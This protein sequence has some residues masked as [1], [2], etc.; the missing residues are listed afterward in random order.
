MRRMLPTIAGLCFVLGLALPVEADPITVTSGVL[1]IDSFG[2][3]FR[4]AFRLDGDNFQAYG[5]T[6]DAATSGTS[7][8]CSLPSCPGGT[9][10][11]LGSTIRPLNMFG[12]AT[13]DGIKYSSTQYVG[14]QLIFSAGDVILPADSQTF[15]NL[16][17]TFTFVGTLDIFAFGPSGPF[18]VGT[19]DLTG[20][21]FA[22]GFFTKGE[23]GYTLT[24]VTYDFVNPTPEP[25]SLLLLGTGVA[26]A[27]RKL[28]A[29]DAA[30]SQPNLLRSM[31]R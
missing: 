12:W 30:G 31:Q 21:G 28:R 27:L 7:T 22:R 13:V 3:P 4:V 19:V 25:G 10:I 16:G 8:A 5:E 14:G 26:M 20:R 11:D 17:T 9:A 1:S 24:G 6:L 18:S 15:L 29:G 2:H 23:N